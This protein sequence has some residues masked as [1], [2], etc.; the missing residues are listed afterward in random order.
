[1]EGG[2]VGIGA[3]VGA[4]AIASLTRWS[5]R[6]SISVEEGPQATNA[7]TSRAGTKIARLLAIFSNNA[8]N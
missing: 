7:R 3:G 1:M 8:H 5:M 2:R 4:A 6:R